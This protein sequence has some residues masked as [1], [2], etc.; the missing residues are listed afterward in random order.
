MT[1]VLP[2]NPQRGGSLCRLHV[3]NEIEAA[4]RLEDSNGF[5]PRAVRF[6]AEAADVV[7]GRDSLKTANMLDML[8][9]KSIKLTCY[10]TRRRRGRVSQRTIRR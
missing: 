3:S 9:D 2:A 1:T 4:R 8:S 6:H 5:G 7:H 10:R